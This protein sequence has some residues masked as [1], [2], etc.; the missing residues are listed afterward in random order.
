MKIEGHDHV[1]RFRVTS[2]TQTDVTHL[3]DLGAFKGHG[4][5]SCQHFEF[6]ILPELDA[7]RIAGKCKHITAC[8]DQLADEV[9]RRVLETEG[10]SP[11][12]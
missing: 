10:P 11:T 4:R 9:I 8:R 7:G 1:L 6:R 3:V 2:E 5:C 12:E